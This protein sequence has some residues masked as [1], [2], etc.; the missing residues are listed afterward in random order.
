MTCS[1]MNIGDVLLDH[2][3]LDRDFDL[4]NEMHDSYQPRKDVDETMRKKVQ[5]I[6]V[7]TSKKNSDVICLKN[8]YEAWLQSE[9][10]AIS[11]LSVMI[12][13]INTAYEG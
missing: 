13:Q 5:Q 4:F 12:R 7:D 2:V 6:F 8:R 11:L 10:D 1:I 9:E 3:L